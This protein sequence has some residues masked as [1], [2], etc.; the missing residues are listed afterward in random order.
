MKH[1]LSLLIVC[2]LVAGCSGLKSETNKNLVIVTGKLSE[3]GMSTFQYGTHTLNSGDKIYA[4]KSVNINLKAYEGKNVI[5]KGT[6][7]AGYPLNGGPELLK[8]LEVIVN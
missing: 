1:L 2:L 5:V 4:L 6:K 3:L 7:I 8:V